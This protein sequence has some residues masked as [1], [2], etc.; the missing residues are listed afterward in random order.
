LPEKA[1]RPAVGGEAREALLAARGAEALRDAAGLGHHP[2]VAA[3]DEGDLRG[4]DVGVAHEARVHLGGGRRGGEG[5]QRERARGAQ[6][7]SEHAAGGV[8]HG[9]EHV[10]LLM[11]AA[12]DRTRRAASARL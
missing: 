12:R 9:L 6:A 2:D 4:G 3:E 11:G 10:V 5:E 1:M 7:G 8:T